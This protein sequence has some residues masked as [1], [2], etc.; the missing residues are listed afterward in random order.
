VSLMVETQPYKGPMRRRS[1]VS[2]YKYI[3]YEDLTHQKIS[4]P[5]TLSNATTYHPSTL[6]RQHQ[7]HSEF[8]PT[9]NS[10]PLR[11]QPLRI[12]PTQDS[13]PLRIHPTQ[14]PPGCDW[15]RILSVLWCVIVTVCVGYMGSCLPKVFKVFCASG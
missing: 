12:Q 3:L 13:T 7:P 1:K 9:Q 2:K 8:N 15:Y 14:D 10:T 6:Y 4:S 5:V 11:I